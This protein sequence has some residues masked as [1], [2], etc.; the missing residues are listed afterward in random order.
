MLV[1]NNLIV[2]G[3]GF[4]KNLGLKTCYSD[5]IASREFQNLTKQNN[6]IAIELTNE[7]GLQ[8]WI[9]IEIFLKRF[10]LQSNRPDVVE[11]HFEKLKN[12]LIAYLESIDVSTMDKTSDAY[13][14]ISTLHKDS[15]ILNFNYTDTVKAIMRE[16]G[17]SDVEIS[18]RVIHVHGT[19]IDKDIIFGV[20]DSARINVSKHV[21]LQKSSNI[22]YKAFDITDYL[23]WDT[24]LYVFGHSLGE[25]DTPYFQTFVD[26]I[27]EF[28]P[29]H[30]GHEKRIFNLYYHGNQSLNDL[31]LR[32]V[33]MTNSNLRIFKKNVQLNF[34]DTLKPSLTT[35]AC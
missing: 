22:N 18:K 29:Q 32:I 25:T 7:L 28:K 13:K 6:D 33:S 10:S 14:L 3:N 24:N 11:E 16:C 26:E 20:E 12:A 31:N 35:I 2:I 21:F 17:V 19:L 5:F 4:D 8:K 1:K 15:I 23:N 30:A 9:D 34:I 27:L